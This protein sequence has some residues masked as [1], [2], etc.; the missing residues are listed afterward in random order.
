[1]TSFSFFLTTLKKFK[2]NLSKNVNTFE[3]IMENGRF[4]TKEQ[5][6]HFPS[7]FQIYDISKAS[8]GVIME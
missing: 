2:K 6:L 5:I 1:M 8:K 7:Y 3:N 4:A